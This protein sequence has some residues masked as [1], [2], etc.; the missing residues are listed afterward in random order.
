MF[1]V[2]LYESLFIFWAYREG[3]FVGFGETERS[4]GSGGAFMLNYSS[5]SPALLTLATT[6]STRFAG[7]GS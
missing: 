5:S 6:S 7:S 3:V 1:F 2:N 4:S